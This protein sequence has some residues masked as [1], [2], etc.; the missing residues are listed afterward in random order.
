[1][2]RE[3]GVTCANP[4]RERMRS[5]IL[6]ARRILDC[7]VSGSSGS[8]RCVE[9]GGGGASRGRV[10]HG[11]RETVRSKL[12]RTVAFAATADCGEKWRGGDAS[13]GV[14][15]VRAQHGQVLVCSKSFL[16]LLTI[17]CRELSSL[18]LPLVLPA[19]RLAPCL[20]RTRCWEVQVLLSLP[21]NP[22]DFIDG[23]S[24]F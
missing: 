21:A 4:E 5:V 12:V 2:V 16:L 10:R 13:T 17:R 1:V 19:P 11:E 18:P 24:T 8:H 23:R 22:C 9:R 20:W 14:F 3:L 15:Q 6:Q 7:Q